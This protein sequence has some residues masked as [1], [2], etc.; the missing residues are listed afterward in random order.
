MWIRVSV[1]CAALNPALPSLSP[2]ESGRHAAG[3][4]LPVAVPRLEG[5]SVVSRTC[6]P[7]VLTSRALLLP[8]RQVATSGNIFGC[9]N[10]EE[11]VL[12][13]FTV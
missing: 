5:T 2:A 9:C 7:V 4:A 12:L 8:R 10:L 3:G 6:G 11:G 1:R 13:T